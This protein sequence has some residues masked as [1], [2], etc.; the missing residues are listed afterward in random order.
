MPKAQTKTR[1]P[2]GAPPA[3]R[4]RAIP[5]GRTGAETRQLIID[6][7][8][9]LIAERGYRE[10]TMKAVA[11]Q[12]GISEPAV[13]RHFDSKARLLVTVFTE[14]VARSPLSG[15]D[16]GQRPGVAAPMSAA[17]LTRTDMR[18]MRRLIVEMYAAA[19]L[20]SDVAELAKRF[21]DDA[22]ENLR[23]QLTEGIGTGELPAG[24]NIVHTQRFMHIFMTGLAHHEVLAADQVGDP[25]WARFVADALCHV[26]GMAGMDQTGEG[27]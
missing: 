21:V 22:A 5:G 12:V 14:A 24:L 7:A 17:V 26:L 16:V 27:S 4:R 2:A 10:T 20:E 3:G 13:Y 8:S 15:G 25:E 11:E 6:M 9:T 23:A 19:A 1:E 18:Q